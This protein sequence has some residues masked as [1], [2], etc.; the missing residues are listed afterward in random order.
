MSNLAYDQIVRD[1]PSSMSGVMI[2]LGIVLIICD[3]F[4]ASRFYSFTFGESSRIIFM[5]IALAIIACFLL[6]SFLEQDLV[7]V[8]LTVCLLGIFVAYMYLFS[9]KSGRDI[10]INAFAQIYG[11][12]SFAVFY[13]MA[14]HRIIHQFLN[15]MMIIISIYLVIYCILAT[16][17]YMGII[18]SLESDDVYTVL[19]DKERG[20]RLFLAGGL[21]T[22]VLAYAATRLTDRIQIAHLLLLALAFTA[23]ILSWSRVFIVVNVILVLIYFTLRS[24][25]PIQIISFCAF[26]SICAYLIYGILAPPFNPFDFSQTDTSTLYRRQE[27][28]LLSEYIRNNPI[29]GVGLYDSEAGLYY[30]LGRSLIF[31]SDLGIVGIWFMFGL[32][33]VFIFG[34]LPAYLCF[35][36]RIDR[37]RTGATVADVRT[38]TF[39]GCSIGISAASTMNMF[40]GADSLMFGMLL[41]LTVFSVLSGRRRPGF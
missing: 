28:I 21:T 16:L 20:N 6:Y 17:Y 36:P 39:V 34:L 12:L 18:D 23:S 7:P 2:F 26:L 24:V 9:A 15:I 3:I 32:V 29:F 4:I 14:R 1:R 41:G 13:Q 25:R 8:I 31:P 10:N 37:R 11:I 19:Y 27:F 40:N 35:Y 5:S 33:G 38:C 30:Y 22:F